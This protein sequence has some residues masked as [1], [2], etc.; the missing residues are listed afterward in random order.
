MA[1]PAPTIRNSLYA[2]DGPLITL[3]Q[4]LAA[5]GVK[6]KY[7]TRKAHSIEVKPG[8][9]CVAYCDL[10]V[11]PE[12]AASCEVGLASRSSRGEEYFYFVC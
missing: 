4:G 11:I 3:E 5:M 7:F 1:R 9:F 6:A 12:T 2:H 8:L 10:H